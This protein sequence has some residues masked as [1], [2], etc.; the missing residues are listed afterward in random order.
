MTSCGC[1]ASGVTRLYESLNRMLVVDTHLVSF[2][3]KPDT[4]AAL[5]SPHFTNHL[6]A[7]AVHTP[8]QSTKSIRFK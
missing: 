4:H 5:Y 7:I 2:L 8:P 3:L 6:L 1:C